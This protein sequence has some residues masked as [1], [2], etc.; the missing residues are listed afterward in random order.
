MNRM[1]R[2]RSRR[3]ALVASLFAALCVSGCVGLQRNPNVA[4]NYSDKLSPYNYREDGLIAM[5]VVGVD[6][7]RF[8]RKE[9]YVPLFVQVVNKSKATFE[10]TRESFLLEDRLGRQYGVAPATEVAAAYARLDIDRRL[11]VQNR[12][13]TSTYVSL[14]TYVASD[15]F[16]SSARRA[17]LVDHVSLPPHAYMEDVL[18]FPVPESGLNDE[19]LR[20]L[21]RVQGMDDP[22]QVVFSVPLTRGILEKDDAGKET[23]KEKSG[24]S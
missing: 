2:N 5:M 17:L 18:Y 19:P 9:P 16:P 14:Y 13:V 8:I 12:G 4:G 11:F 24:G 10:V 3:A 7:A 22:I 6:G 15:F 23:S 20:L 1:E 21:F